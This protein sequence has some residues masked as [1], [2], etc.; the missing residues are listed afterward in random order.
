MFLIC[1]LEIIIII[2]FLYM[3]F[4][5]LSVLYKKDI[6]KDIDIFFI[7]STPWEFKKHKKDIEKNKEGD[8]NDK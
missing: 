2:L 5:L 7:T 6:L 3:F 4:R 1:F 8:L